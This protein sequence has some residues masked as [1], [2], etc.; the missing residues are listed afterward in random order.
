MAQVIPHQTDMDASEILRLYA[1]GTHLSCRYCK[2]ELRTI[3]EQLQPGQMPLYLQCPNN[4]NHMA[5]H[6][7]PAK[8]MQ[9]IR[10]S[11]RRAP[12]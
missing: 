12:E 9:E 2:V 3:P 1:A 6:C 4:P 8:G 11:T 7:D 10:K 5:L